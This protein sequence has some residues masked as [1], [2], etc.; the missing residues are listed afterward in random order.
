MSTL[1]VLHAIVIILNIFS[2][3]LVVLTRQVD[4]YVHPLDVGKLYCA[5]GICF[6]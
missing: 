3:F 1:D 2:V 6:G 5:S 4:W